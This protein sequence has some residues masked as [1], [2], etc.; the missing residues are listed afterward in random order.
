MMKKFTVLDLSNSL[1]NEI[2]EEYA[3]DFEIVK[4]QEIKKKEILK[5]VTGSDAILLSSQGQIDKEIIDNAPN[6]KVIG[7]IGTGYQNVD[8]EEASRKRIYVVYSGTANSETVADLAFGLLLSVTRN[9]CIA[10]HDMKLTGDEK[11]DFKTGEKYIGIDVWRKTIG[12]IGF[13][14]IGKC[15]AKR[16]KGFEMQILVHDPFI[17]ITEDNEVKLCDKNELLSVAD[18]V[19][20]HIPFTEKNRNCIDSNE[21]KIMKK[22]SIL[23]NAAYGGLVNEESLYQALINKEIAGA[24]IDTPYG[25]VGELSFNPQKKLYNLRNVVVSPFLGARTIECGPRSVTVVLEQILRVLKGEK[26]EFSHNVL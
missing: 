19:T 7:R 23:I 5:H 14:R 26:P 4:C 9:I 20:I 13:G 17:K 16:A 3:S 22:S 15:I 1:N 6:L 2:R 18:F 8:I 12:V 25:E 10:N 24:G 21:F 11:W